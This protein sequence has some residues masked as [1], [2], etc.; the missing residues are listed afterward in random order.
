[1]R[2]GPEAAGHEDAETLLE[3]AVGSGP[4]HRDHADVVEHRL[5]AVGGAAR[6]VELE[7]AG[8][9]L[10]DG[11]ADEMP[12]YRL[13]PRADVEHLERAGAGQMAALHVA[14]GVA[15]RLPGRQADRGEVAHDVGDPLQLHEVELD[16]LAGGDVAPTPR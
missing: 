10:G 6:E 2:V 7:L 1:M 15:A 11:G 12:V 14:D 9:P 16:V 5:A 3:G 8:Q 13:G 4:R